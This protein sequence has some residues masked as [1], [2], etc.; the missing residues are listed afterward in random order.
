MNSHN[1]Q[2]NLSKNNLNN[3][4]DINNL[5]TETQSS[6]NCEQS[7]TTEYLIERFVNNMSSAY[8]GNPISSNSNNS[9][10]DK[11][12]GTQSVN[13]KAHDSN[14]FLRNS[15]NSSQTNNN[16]NNNIGNKSL[17][18][19]NQKSSTTATSWSSVVKSTTNPVNVITS[20][21]NTSLSGHQYQ[22]QLS[23]TI[24]DELARTPTPNN[25]VLS[26]N[27][28]QHHSSSCS[29]SSMEHH[30]STDEG[31]TLALSSGSQLLQTSGLFLV[32]SS[33]RITCKRNLYK[34][35]TRVDFF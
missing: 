27:L 26:K 7:T 15:N 33:I 1:Q 9:N 13:N 32:H 22:Q 35:H 23:E 5:S 17:N 4:F 10:L 11:S 31:N 6:K 2:S 29:S 24:V 18:L 30:A 28:K 34:M 14:I 19:S 3:F 12:N 20:S 16:N 21:S 25:F 8:N